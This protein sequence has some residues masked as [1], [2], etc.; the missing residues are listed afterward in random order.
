MHLAF[1]FLAGLLALT[2]AAPLEGENLETRAPRAQ[3]IRT[4][5]KPMHAALTFV[6]SFISQGFSNYAHSSSYVG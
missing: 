2:L 4:C 3:V 6:E 5:Q 1:V